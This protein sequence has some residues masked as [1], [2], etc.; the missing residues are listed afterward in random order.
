[1]ADFS[2]SED[3]IPYPLPP[4]TVAPTTTKMT[5]GANASKVPTSLSATF[6]VHQK[7]QL[8]Q[9]Q[10]QRSFWKRKKTQPTLLA[11]VQVIFRWKRLLLF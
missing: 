1:M 7:N 11:V 4:T 3:E 10:R 2:N 8:L 5:E 9:Q 6:K